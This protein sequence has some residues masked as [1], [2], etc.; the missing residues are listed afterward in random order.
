[1]SQPHLQA[2][3]RALNRK[4]WRIVAVLSGN[5]YNVSATWQIQRGASD[6][7]LLIDFDGLDDM[8]CLPLEESYGCH[9]RGRPAGDETASLYVRK[10]NRSRSLWEQDLAAFVLALDKAQDTARE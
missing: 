9:V 1:M 2:L 8:I 10:P 5:D 4:G 7:A 3:E 6:P